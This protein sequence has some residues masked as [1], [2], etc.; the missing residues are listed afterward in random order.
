MNGFAKLF[1]NIVTSTIW[2]ED[3]ETRL[4]WITMLAISDKY[5]NVSGSIPGLAQISRVSVKGCR[6]A[7]QK[8]L[9]PD[10]DSRTQEHEGCRIEEIEGGWHIINYQKYREMQ[11]SAERR[12]YLRIKKRESREKLQHTKNQNASYNAVSNAISEGKLSSPDSYEC[13]HCHQ[14]AKEYHHYLGY[15]KEHWLDIQPVCIPCHKKIHKNPHFINFSSTDVNQ[16]QPIAEAEAEAKKK[17]Y[18]KK[19]KSPSLKEFIQY[20]DENKLTISNPESLWHGYEDCD[21]PWHD[22]QG[23]P[24][25]NWKMKLRTLSDVKAKN[26]NSGNRRNFENQSSQYGQKI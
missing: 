13:V 16:F 24:V 14:K 2:C 10:P 26:G 7:I 8:F 4:V 6:N 12:E 1:G 9:S 17:I 15:E 22:T 25:K 23:K 19:F 21:P 11:R 3:N 5:G 20:I 18:K